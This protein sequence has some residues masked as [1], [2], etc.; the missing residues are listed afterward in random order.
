MKITGARQHGNSIWFGVLGIST[1]AAAAAAAAA[2]MLLLL[3]QVIQHPLQLPDL[4][5]RALVLPHHARGQLASRSHLL[6]EAREPARVVLFVLHY[7]SMTCSGQ[8]LELRLL[9]YRLQ[10]PYVHVELLLPL[11]Q[12]G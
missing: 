6:G 5:E 10:V 9:R 8:F 2:A 3:E 4:G 11:V 7:L 1:V 12:L